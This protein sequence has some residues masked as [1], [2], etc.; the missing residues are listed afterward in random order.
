M[1]EALPLAFKFM[2]INELDFTGCFE[3]I[4]K[5]FK[6]DRGSFVKTYHESIF[7]EN[8]IEFIT[9]EEFYST[10]KKNVFRGLHFQSPPAAHNK[11]VYCAKG[12]V[13][14][15]LV[16]LRKNSPTY[17]K[18]LSIFL[19]EDNGR[20]LYIPIGIAHGF[21]SISDDSLMVYKTDHVYCP[22]EDSGILWSSCD[23]ALSSKE[24]II[25][26]RDQKFESIH[27]FRSPF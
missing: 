11:L 3:I 15:F 9:K 22:E 26:E 25:S 17:G 18:S 12:E 1:R 27:D 24:L 10:S 2:M 13:T 20:I 4:P 14:D 5:I 21:L 16:D 7:L 23:L 6:D 8:G 19:S